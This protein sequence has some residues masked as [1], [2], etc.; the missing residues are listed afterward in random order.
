MDVN[1]AQID[2]LF[3]L[4]GGVRALVDGEELGQFVELVVAFHKFIAS[5]HAN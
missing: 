5:Q 4:A 2:L 3:E 1:L